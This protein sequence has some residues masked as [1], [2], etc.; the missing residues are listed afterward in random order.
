MPLQTAFVYL[1]AFVFHLTQ[2]EEGVRAD[3]DDGSTVVSMATA[4]LLLKAVV[5][6]LLFG[7]LPPL[8]LS[9]L[10]DAR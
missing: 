3:L 4:I 1:V 2:A 8:R 9:V 6:G 5:V 7:Y 10:Q